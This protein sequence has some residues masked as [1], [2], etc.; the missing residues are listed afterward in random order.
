MLDPQDA[1]ALSL[2]RDGDPQPHAIM[3]TDSQFSVEWNERFA[4]D[5]DRF[6]VTGK[7]GRSRTIL[8]YPTGEIAERCRQI[9]HGELQPRAFSSAQMDV[10]GGGST[11][12]GRPER[13][14][15]PR[16]E[17][18]ESAGPGRVS[19]APRIDWD[20]AVAGVPTEELFENLDLD[21]PGDLRE[22]LELF[23]WMLEND[24]YLT[25]EAVI[26][27][28]QGLPLSEEDE[29]RL[30]GLMRFVGDEDEEEDEER[31]LFI[32][33][34]ARPTEPWY[35]SLRRLAPRLL[36]PKVRTGE[37]YHEVQIEGWSRVREALEEHGEGLS[38]PLD[39]AAPLEVVPE[40]LRRRLDLQ[41]CLWVLIGIGQE[42]SGGD[43]TTLQDPREHWRVDDLIED[44]RENRESVAF[45]ELTLDRLLELAVMPPE[46]RE[47]FVSL[48]HEKLGLSSGKERMAGHL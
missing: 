21:E 16:R 40:E 38:L 31:I 6:V 33:Q 26:R 42:H 39:A 18:A 15:V 28:E 27:N 7:T 3:E 24:D 14:A 12:P 43:R 23:T 8:G 48:M 36:L 1:F 47:I 20:L 5:G 4:I 44:L 32:D 2:A 41:C 25:W 29:G 10:A 45:V 46:E 37:L 35:E 9:L 13:R 22:A 19:G 17:G 34:I 30:D 11:N